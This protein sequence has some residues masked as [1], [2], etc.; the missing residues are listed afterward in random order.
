MQSVT[1]VLRRAAL[2]GTPVAWFCLFLSGHSRGWVSS[3]SLQLLLGLSPL[4]LIAYG[5]LLDQLVRCYRLQHPEHADDSQL[6][7]SLSADLLCPGSSRSG[8][9]GS[10]WNNSQL[11]LT[12]R[13]PGADVFIGREKYL[14]DLMKSISVPSAGSVCPVI[15]IWTFLPVKYELFCSSPNQ[16]FLQS[17]CPYA[18]TYSSH[19]SHAHLSNA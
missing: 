19:L 13:Q 8:R 6:F 7:V 15:T 1:N 10:V 2:D 11:H 3:L 9:H 4:L 18:I 12:L 17:D 14:E 16:H 5:K